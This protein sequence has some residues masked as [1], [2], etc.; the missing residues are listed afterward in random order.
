MSFRLKTILGIAFIEALLLS[1]LL[2]V[3]L[4]KL[5]TTNEQAL[6]ERARETTSLFSV[7]VKDA[8]LTTD[9]ATIA[10]FATDVMDNSGPLYVR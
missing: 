6:I 1:L 9:L 10:S 7:A 2:F 4:D 3:L 5:H 8:V